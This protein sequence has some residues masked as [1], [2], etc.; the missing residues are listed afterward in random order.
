[1]DIL[2]NQFYSN[3]S[4]NIPLK[5]HTEFHVA[6]QHGG[7]IVT[8]VYCDV[9]SPYVYKAFITSIQNTGWH[10]INRTIYFCRPS[11][12]FLQQNT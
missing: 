6:S 5:L 10:R 3:N 12:V 11:S 8:T 4:T 9:T 7:H 2:L 1:M